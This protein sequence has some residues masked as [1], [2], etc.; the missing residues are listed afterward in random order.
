[1]LKC[2]EDEAMRFLRK[3]LSSHIQAAKNTQE[4]LQVDEAAQCLK[5]E[6]RKDLTKCQERA[7]VHE[8]EMLEFRQEYKKKRRDTREK[9]GGKKGKGAAIPWKGPKEIKG[10]DLDH[11]PQKECKQFMPPLS[12]LWRNRTS[13]AWVSRYLDMPTRSARDSAWGSEGA[14]LKEVIRWAW[15]CYLDDNGYDRKMC[16]IADLWQDSEASGSGVASSFG[17]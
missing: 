5:D 2:T 10:V 3:R 6:D 11:L 13:G 12:Y 1:M 17:A 15:S 7:L 8:Q 14:A 4:L 9:V 16:P